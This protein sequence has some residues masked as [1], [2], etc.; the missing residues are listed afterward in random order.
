M[1]ARG[2]SLRLPKQGLRCSTCRRLTIR[3]IFEPDDEADQQRPQQM[4]K[5]KQLPSDKPWDGEES[6]AES[7][8]RMIMD[9]YR[10]PLRVEG[11]ARRQLPQPQLHP[12]QVQGLFE[13]RSHDNISSGQKALMRDKSVRSRKQKRLM[14][15]REAALDYSLSQKYPVEQKDET[16]AN[17]EEPRPR[18]IN[19][20]QSLAEERIREARAR[21]DF[22]NLP[23]RGKPIPKDIYEDSPFLDR[24][25]YFLNRIIQRQGAAPPWV[26]MQQEVDTETSNFRTRLRS[27][28]LTR[29]DIL[30][31]EKGGNTP[32]R[33]AILQYWDENDGEYFR[34][35]LNH[36]NQRLRSYNVMCPP[37]VRKNRLLFERE[38]NDMLDVI[39]EDSTRT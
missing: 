32:D 17:H 11:A 34:V 30:Y 2:Y 25:E 21:G 16:A 7:V 18:S 27:S 38:V 35:H 19:E 6:V 39:L 15:A 13:E 28:I 8:L 36:L 4:S 23:G 29:V 24:T 12:N 10:A 33:R 31:R 26:M 5:R 1:L 9:K 20:I 22:D 37:S 3:S 14:N